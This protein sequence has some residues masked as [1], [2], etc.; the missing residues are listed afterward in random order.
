MNNLITVENS[1]EVQSIINDIMTIYT[2]MMDTK[3]LSK[4]GYVNHDKFQH[5]LTFLAEKYNLSY[6]TEY[7][8][9]LF[10]DKFKQKTY[11]GRIDIVYYK[12]GEPYIS[13]EIDS[14]LKGTSIKKLIHNHEFPYKLWFCYN[15]KA[16]TKDYFD[17]I[18]KI[19]EN[20]DVIY[21]TPSITKYP[22]KLKKAT[23]IKEYFDNVGIS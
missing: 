23:N 4:M 8:G 2:T 14:G 12:N 18:H 22:P 9:K 6:E 13:L 3:Q 11:S 17:L 20:R 15:K 16:N 5:Y 1:K 10:Y 7:N 19:D 21:L